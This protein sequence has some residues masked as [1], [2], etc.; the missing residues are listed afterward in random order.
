LTGFEWK[1]GTALCN[2]PSGYKDMN[3]EEFKAES[4]RLESLSDKE[5][6]QDEN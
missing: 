2:S 4:E 5:M 6:K 3:E 1:Y